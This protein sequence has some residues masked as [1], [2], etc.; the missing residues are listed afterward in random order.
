MDRWMDA[1]MD[2]YVFINI[3]IRYY[4]LNNFLYSS[5]GYLWFVII[6]I[7]IYMYI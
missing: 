6:K 2:S 5:H 4:L 3:I 1:L 7:A